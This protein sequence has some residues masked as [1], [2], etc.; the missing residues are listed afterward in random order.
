MTPAGRSDLL[1]C[2]KCRSHCPHGTKTCPACGMNLDT[3][4][5]GAVAEPPASPNEVTSDRLLDLRLTPGRIASLI[6]WA[7][8]WAIAVLGFVRSGRTAAI[9]FLLPVYAIQPMVF[10]WF[11]EAMAGVS[12]GWHGGVLKFP[13]QPWLVALCGWGLL[14][15]IPVLVLVVALIS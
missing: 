10:I 1:Y 13:D 11:P 12:V 9:G 15:G 8:Y 3:S 7:G 14:V 4:E 6:V 5:P 2:W